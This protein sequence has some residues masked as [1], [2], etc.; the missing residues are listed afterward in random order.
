MS[1]VSIADARDILLDL[2]PDAAYGYFLP[3]AGG[4]LK[5][6]H[7]RLKVDPIHE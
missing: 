2:A 6:K 1:S 5:E 3:S 7:F 4:G